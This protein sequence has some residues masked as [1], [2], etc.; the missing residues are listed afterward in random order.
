M[1]SLIGH[2]NMRK[3]LV[4]VKMHKRNG[5]IVKTH[6]RKDDKTIN[7]SRECESL[8]NKMPHAHI[9]PLNLNSLTRIKKKKI[10]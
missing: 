4:Q 7:P 10:I 2:Q 6:F 1:S 3:K 5:R 9:R 8:L